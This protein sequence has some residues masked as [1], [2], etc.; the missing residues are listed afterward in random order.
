MTATPDEDWQ[1]GDPLYRREDHTHSLYAFNFRSDPDGEECHCS[2]AASWPE[3]TR[4]RAIKDGD[5]L[6]DLI[7]W[8]RAAAADLEAGS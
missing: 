5:E 7:A 3:P 1:P 6:G 8:H 4:H 2:D